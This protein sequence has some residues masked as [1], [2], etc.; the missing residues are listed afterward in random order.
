MLTRLLLALLP[1]MLQ[2]PIRRLMGANIGKGAHVRFGTI[3]YADKVDIG[4]N[5]SIGPFTFIRARTF[6]AGA[7]CNI[8]PLTILKASHIDVGAYSHIGST[9]IVTS[10]LEKHSHFNLGDHSLINPFCFIESGEGVTIGNQTGIGG[11]SLIFTHASWADYLRG[12]HVAYGPVVIEDEVWITW[13][14]SILANVIIGKNAM[15][16]AGA[17]VNKSVPANS[18][19]VGVP[20]RVI[21][22]AVG[23]HLSDSERSQR[24]HRI[25][26]DYAENGLPATERPEPR[27]SADRLQFSSVIAIDQAADL[28]RG[29]LLFV[30]NQD[31]SDSD[32]QAFIARGVTVLDHR[33]RKIFVATR[34]PYVMDFVTFLN[35]Y[36]IRLDIE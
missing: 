34:R 14:V 30:L 20:A 11:N 13:R 10:E 24:A 21:P 36:G 32:R 1:S 3:L 25:L 9:V 23:R 26:A 19:A 27:L 12:G 33:N 6:K 16:A 17:V 7:H 15:I 35:R 4:P 8:K 2:V 5:A 28:N 29:D 31:V 22:G 18:L